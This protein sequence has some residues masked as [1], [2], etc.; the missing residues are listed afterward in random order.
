MGSTDGS[1]SA[2]S[3]TRPPPTRHEEI[4]QDSGS[5][6]AGARERGGMTEDDAGAAGVV[7]CV[8]V[9][10]IA[11]RRALGTRAGDSDP[12]QHAMAIAPIPRHIGATRIV[13]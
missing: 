7:T 6:G 8:A 3:G 4:K 9:G 13:M 1:M 11:G 2:D 10:G 12:F 5:R